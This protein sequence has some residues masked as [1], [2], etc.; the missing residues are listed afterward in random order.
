M[1]G[2][3]ILQSQAGNYLPGYSPQWWRA[4][5]TNVGQ[6]NHKYIVW[7]TDLIS[8]TMIKEKIPA[9]VSDTHLWY[10]SGTFAE[11]FL[12]QVNPDGLYDFQKNTGALRKIRVVIGE[13]Y[14]SPA[15]EY[16]GSNNDYYIWNGVLNFPDFPNYQVNDYIYNR[17]GNTNPQWITNNHN[18]AYSYGW[19]ARSYDET[20]YYNRSSFLYCIAP[21]AG[22]N[23]KLEIKGYD[24]S[25]NLLSTSYISNTYSAG[26]TYTDKYTFINVGY[27][28]LANIPVTNVT[29][30]WPIPVSTF[31]HYTVKDITTVVGNVDQ[32]VKTFY[33]VCEPRFDV[34]TLH[35]L[36]KPGSFETWN[37]TKLSERTS[38]VEKTSY[39]KYPYQLIGSNV[40]YQTGTGV[41]QILSVSEQNK[42][43]VSSDWLTVEECKRLKQLVTSPL[44]YMDEGSGFVNVRMVTNSYTELKKYNSKLISVQ[45]DLEYNHSN[46]SQ[47]G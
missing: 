2:I 44:I 37:F 13:E 19:T 47:R 20:T 9:R 1:A 31:D 35:Y 11:T 41:T 6:P 36:S 22:E 23:E 18:A 14:G 15:A 40:T 33:V 21:L 17:A 25:N 29:G 3:T 5:S 12:T 27:K 45:F 7:V 26:T 24:S 30:T 46:W 43:K 10:N 42:I 34:V 16:G 39:G 28:G 38:S 4:S 32:P 8:G